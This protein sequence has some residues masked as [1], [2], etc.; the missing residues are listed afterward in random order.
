MDFTTW[1]SQMPAGNIAVVMGCVGMYS[2]VTATWAGFQTRRRADVPGRSLIALLTLALIS[3]P[4]LYLILGHPSVLG[5]AVAVGLLLFFVHRDH[6]ITKQ[7]ERLGF[8][9]DPD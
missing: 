5:A 1:I 4:S 6:K 7:V 8:E 2:A 3:A 9:P